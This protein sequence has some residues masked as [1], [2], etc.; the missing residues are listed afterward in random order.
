MI[1]LDGGAEHRSAGQLHALQQHAISFS[2]AIAAI[3]SRE[4][5][6]LDM[7]VIADGALRRLPLIEPRRLALVIE[8]TARLRRRKLFVRV[9]VNRPGFVGGFDLTRGWSHGSTE[10]VPG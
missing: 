4:A 10:E 9:E 3:D 7:P 1:E 5:R 8:R 2:I 6:G